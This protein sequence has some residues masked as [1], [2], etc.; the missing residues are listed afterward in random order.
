MQ[1]PFRTALHR[2][3]ASQERAFERVAHN[4][5]FRSRLAQTLRF[6]H[7]F[8]PRKPF[9]TACNGACSC[10]TCASHPRYPTVE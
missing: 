2:R 1:R 7:V 10:R 8:I 5:R 9:E 3:I 6:E 4:V